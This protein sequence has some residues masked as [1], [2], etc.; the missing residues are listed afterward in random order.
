MAQESLESVGQAIDNLGDIIAQGKDSIFANDD[1][2]SESSDSRVISASA[3]DLNTRPYSRLD[4]QIRGIQCDLNTY[5]REVEEVEEFNEW[6]VGFVLDDKREEIEDLV[7]ENGVIQEIYNE[8]VPSKVDRETFWG[9]Y[10]FRVDRVR[11]AE[12]ARVKIVKR[13]ISG[14]GEE[15][16]GWDDDDYEDRCLK[17][18]DDDEEENDNDEKLEG[19]VE[20]KGLEKENVVDQGDVGGSKSDDGVESSVDKLLVKADEK[21]TP[22]VKTDSDISVISS[23]VS[24]EEDDL[25]WDEIEDIGS[26]DEHKVAGDGSPERADLRKRLSASAGDEEED[27]TWD[28]EDDDEPV[29]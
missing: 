6:K 16:L 27:L 1:Y 28:I 11:K 13:A 4:A 17:K 2:D 8:V 20:G 7:E 18:E 14:E 3:Y 10:F 21:I 12:E 15:D 24:H 23:Q 29:K 5:C 25:G 22:E 9:R 26:S 19:N